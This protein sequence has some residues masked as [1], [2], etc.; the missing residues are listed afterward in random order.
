MS[1]DPN[2]DHTPS[3]R[4]DILCGVKAIAGYTGNS[5]RRTVYLLE[6]GLL[7]AG[8]VGALW[9]ASKAKLRCHYDA[10]TGGRAA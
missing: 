10:I 5:E 1:N 6:R 7:P 8:K 9:I 4:D 2:L 3:L